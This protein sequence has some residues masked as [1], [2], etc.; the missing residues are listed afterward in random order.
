MWQSAVLKPVVHR[1]EESGESITTRDR[2]FDALVRTSAC[3]DSALD[4]PA[5]NKK[6]DPGND[7]SALS[8]NVI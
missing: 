2:S 7:D 5:S 3:E 6:L 1:Q 8:A 4:V